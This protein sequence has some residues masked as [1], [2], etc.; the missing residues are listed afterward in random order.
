MSG[1]FFETE[2]PEERGGRRRRRRRRSDERRGIYLLPQLFTTANLFFG[3]FSLIQSTQGHFD[4][5]AGGIVLAAIFDALD[6]RVARLSRATSRFGSEYDSLADMVSFG[7]AP[8]FL[9]Y[10]AGDLG[11]LERTGWI[12][13]FLFTACAALR[14]AR[15]NVHSSRFQGRFEGLPS[16]AAAGMVASTQWFDTFLRG[17]GYDVNLPPLV[18]G[19]GLAS[20]A[21]LMVSAVPYRSFK[22]IDLR[23][24]FRTLV[25]IIV[26]LAVVVQEPSL[27]LFAIGVAY[28]TS[29]PAEWAWRS[30]A[31][32]H[33]EPAA[34]S[35][36]IASREETRV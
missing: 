4:R 21:L 36:S 14:L 25:L 35:E 27:W 24:G 32:R 3:F 23:H 5:A 15:F 26:A 10:M 13:A 6:G 2:R 30:L 28:V 1:P 34:D 9:A 7:V 8:A 16:P 20:L 33:L 17:Q 18:I 31:G 11:Q 29:G 22:E 12:L 19:S